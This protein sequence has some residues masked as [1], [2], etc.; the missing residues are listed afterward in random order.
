[1]G[2]NIVL[3]ATL[4]TKGIE[5]AFI[6][7]IITSKRLRPIVIDSGV[8]GQP[9]IRADISREQVAKAG[10][11]SLKNLVDANDRG[12]AVA[13]MA[14]GAEKI[15][16]KM[17]ASGELDAIIS[18]GGSAG[19]T[20]GTQAMR[21]LPV[22]VPKLMVST[23]A[24]GDTRPY[25]GTKD[26]TMMYSVVDISGINRISRAVFANAANAICA[27][28]RAKR[29]SKAD[30]PLLAATMFGVTTPCVEKVRSALETPGVGFE[31]LVFHATGTGGQAMEGLISD[32]MITGVLDITTTELADE[33]VGGVLSAGPDRLEA[34]GKAGIPQVICPGAIDM[35]NFGPKE[36]VPAKFK[37]RLFHVHN[38]TVTLMRT[39]PSE[40]K[41]L[42][43]ITATKL[44]RA[45]GPTAAVIPLMGVSQIDAPGYSFHDPKA[46]KAYRDAFMNT[47]N[48]KKVLVKQ[49]DANIN[50]DIF[51]AEVVATFLEISAP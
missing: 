48:S 9:K 33:L 32:G 51:A 25:V 18:I 7:D 36:T 49:I 23:L 12:A 37:N 19:T 50:D 2:K 34:A 38:P 43:E 39:T 44:N 10:G 13:V 16:T 14:N 17:H 47:I 5:A 27:M 31:L 11:S 40:N 4:D 24:S 45:K 29:T 41:L 30:K 46:D 3:V 42:G 35:V 28:A 22:G 15:V 1:M 8:Q 21:A 6:R 20:I 26:V